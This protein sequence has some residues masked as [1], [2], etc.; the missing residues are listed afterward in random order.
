[1]ETNCDNE[2]AKQYHNEYGEWL[3]A[4]PMKVIQ[5][6]QGPASTFR[7]LTT[8]KEGEDK[9]DRN[10]SPQHSERRR[11]LLQ[12][13]EEEKEGEGESREGDYGGQKEGLTVQ[14]GRVGLRDKNKNVEMG[15]ESSNYYELELGGETVEGAFTGEKTEGGIGQDKVG[16]RREET[17]KIRKNGKSRLEG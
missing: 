11:S 16:E 10:E 4:S 13:L 7:R 17:G 2:E 14:M 9:R 3:R 5:D 6:R 1:M 12:E 8:E 15:V